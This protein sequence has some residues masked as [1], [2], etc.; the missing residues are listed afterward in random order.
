M[1]E[2]SGQ[3]PSFNQINSSNLIKYIGVIVTLGSALVTVTAFV[4]KTSFPSSTATEALAMAKENK[5]IIDSISDSSKVANAD[6]RLSKLEVQ[7][8][9]SI[10]NQKQIQT[11]LDKITDMMMDIRRNTK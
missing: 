3:S 1:A 4:V 8:A 5:H 7:Y 11:Q 9:N 6:V 10:E 2:N